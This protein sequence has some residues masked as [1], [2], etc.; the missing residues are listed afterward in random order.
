MKVEFRSSFAKDM[1]K[2]KD[3]AIKKQVAAVIAHAEQVNNP[4]ELEDL[5]K[6]KGAEGY[7]RIRIDD[8]RLG[9][10]VDQDKIVFVRF[11]H[12][13]DIYRYFP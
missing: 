10:I 8:Y 3:T 12:R 9:L 7:Y 11:L 1:H 13:K 2:V 4:Y 5:K 6:L